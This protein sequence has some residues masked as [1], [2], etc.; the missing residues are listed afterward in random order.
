MW[1]VSFEGRSQCKFCESDESQTSEMVK[2][3]A[4]CVYWPLATIAEDEDEGK[5]CLVV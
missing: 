4:V 2:K 3:V 1:I 5:Y